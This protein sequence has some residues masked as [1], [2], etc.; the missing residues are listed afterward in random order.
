M[1]FFNE[2]DQ[3]FNGFVDSWLTSLL[4]EDSNVDLAA[5]F[6]KTVKQRLNEQFESL[7]RIPFIS[8]GKLFKE[9]FK[10]EEGAGAHTPASGISANNSFDANLS[11]HPFNGTNTLF[12]GAER[13][14]TESVPPK[15]TRMT[16]QGDQP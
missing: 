14:L 15:N 11:D 13:R 9:F 12:S 6:D 1:T 16:L 5:E 10:L 7:V 3:M 4:R 8:N 2:L